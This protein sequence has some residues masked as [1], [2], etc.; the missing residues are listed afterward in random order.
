[1]KFF[2]CVIAGLN[3]IFGLLPEK[4]LFVVIDKTFFRR[5]NIDITYERDK[6][7]AFCIGVYGAAYSGIYG[8][9]SVGGGFFSKS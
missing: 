5:Y 7:L 8:R 1:M 3:C 4:T 6:C 2:Y 9:W